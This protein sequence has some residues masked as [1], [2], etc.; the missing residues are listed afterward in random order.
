M[1]PAAPLGVQ[2][3]GRFVAFVH[4][5]CNDARIGARYHGDADG[6][7]PE[8]QAER[9]AG[10]G[11][12]QHGDVHKTGTRIRFVRGRPVCVDAPVGVGFGEVYGEVL[13][14]GEVAGVDGGGCF[15][16]AGFS[17]AV[18]QQR[19]DAFEVEFLPKFRR[20]HVLEVA[21]PVD[22]AAVDA[23]GDF[24]GDVHGGQPIVG[25]HQLL[26]GDL[27]RDRVWSVVACFV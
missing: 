27:R 4:A 22:L 23:V 1:Q 10:R 8:G 17:P 12:F 18:F 2:V 26:V 7:A 21:F 5:V 24:F 9:G 15:F 25:G 14:F 19:L 6:V 13:A 11:R 3:H 16:D 20:V